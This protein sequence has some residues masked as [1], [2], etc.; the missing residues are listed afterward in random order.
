MSQAELLLFGGGISL[1][2]A[3]L[4]TFANGV[5]AGRLAES[6]HSHARELAREQ[7]RHAD[8]SSA[9]IDALVA[10]RRTLV[11]MARTA[12]G[13]EPAPPVPDPPPDGVYWHLTARVAAYGSEEIKNYL[14]RLQ[15]VEHDFWVSV[16]LLRDL[17]RHP[18]GSASNIEPID[19]RLKL[20]GHRAEAG[21]ILRDLEAQVAR[22]LQAPA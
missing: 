3:L 14:E 11:V 16:A 2:T 7:R 8:K 20:D 4:T 5:W 10:A 1:V 12:P 18:T 6:S 9:Y 13:F 21:G 17:E 19:V 15:D 22:E